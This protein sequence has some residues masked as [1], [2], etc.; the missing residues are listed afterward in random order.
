L[1]LRNAPRLRRG[2]LSIMAEDPQELERLERRIADV[3]H[4]IEWARDHHG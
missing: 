4:C 1:I 2:Y 3:R